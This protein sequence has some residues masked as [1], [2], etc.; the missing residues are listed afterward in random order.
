MNAA[1]VFGPPGCGKST[2]LSREIARRVEAQGIE[3]VSRTTAV[4]SFTRAAA[5]E[6]ASKIDSKISASTMHSL[7]Y[8]IC[9]LVR[10]QVIGW[11]HMNE[12]ADLVGVKFSNRSME[13]NEEET[14]G[15]VALSL[16]SL[17]RARMIP[18]S[19][20]YEM[21]TAPVDP[22]LLKH[23]VESYRKWKRMR[24]Y[25][26]FTDML[27]MSL[28]NPGPPFKTLIV[29][30]AQDLST[31]Q[32]AVLDHWITQGVEEVILA[33]DD[34]Q[35]IYVW[36]GADPRGMYDFVKRYDAKQT[37][38]NQSYRLPRAVHTFAER[39]SESIIERVDKQF[40]PREFPGFVGELPM[41][42]VTQQVKHGTDALILYRCHSMRHEMEKS[43]VMNG[44]P[45]QVLTGAPGVLQGKQRRAV[46]LYL[47]LQKY[48]GGDATIQVS[49]AEERQ[50]HK[51]LRP[52][53]QQ[54]PRKITTTRWQDALNLSTYH[55][56]YLE[57]I[58]KRYGLDVKPTVRL[59]TIHGA[60]GREAETVILYN[61]ISQRIRN[62]LSVDGQDAEKRVFYVG[63]TRAKE[64]L[65]IVNGEM[66]FMWQG[67]AMTW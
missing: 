15:D 16:E 11:A 43:L 17:A 30:E 23:V 26:D 8:G 44:I 48:L 64:K 65:F 20:V 7:C 63:V 51:F 18:I 21:S 27:E 66:P 46:D 9:G 13:D 2:Y 40:L 50:L 29:D 49:K 12:F 39:V 67:G 57:Q 32:Y 42:S 60:K 61:S 47:K 53:V 5:G 34:D 6:I 55:R 28:H 24:G 10:E 37:V 19:R 45:Y 33:G 14:P 56:I 38:L 41:F 1:V 4:L 3:D 22:T 54:N 36:G 31:L 52:E 25:V 59:S 58:E 35:A 62:S